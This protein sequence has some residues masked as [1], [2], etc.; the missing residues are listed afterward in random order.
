M[1]DSLQVSWEG[2]SFYNA[3]FYNILILQTDRKVNKKRK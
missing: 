3:K 2:S 1:T